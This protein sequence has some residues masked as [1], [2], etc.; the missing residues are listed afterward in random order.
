DQGTGIDEKDIKYIFQPFYRAASVSK[1]PGHGIGLSLTEN[2]IRLH[3]GTIQ[4]TSQ[5]GK[6]TKV[7]ISLPY[8]I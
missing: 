8:S 7:S 6:G 3:E 1:I 5:P 2:I 4:L